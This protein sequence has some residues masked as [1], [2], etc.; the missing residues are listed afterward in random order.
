[1][2]PK[3]QRKFEENANIFCPFCGASGYKGEMNFF[4]DTI[5]CIYCKKD[6]SKEL[7]ELWKF[8]A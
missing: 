5:K 2:T 6:V 1:M 4:N 7:L 8:G 3:P